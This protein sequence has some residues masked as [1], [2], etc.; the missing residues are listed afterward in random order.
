LYNVYIIYFWENGILERIGTKSI[1]I[2]VN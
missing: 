2:F 1:R